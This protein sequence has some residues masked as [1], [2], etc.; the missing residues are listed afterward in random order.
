MKDLNLINEIQG[1]VTNI[2]KGTPPE[3]IHYIVNV[4]DVMKVVADY[5]LKALEMG[6]RAGRGME[7][8]R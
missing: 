5:R 1:L 6:L 4:A 8:D 2:P 7:D 3:N